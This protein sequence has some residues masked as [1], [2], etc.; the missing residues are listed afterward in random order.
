[1]IARSLAKLVRKHHPDLVISRTLTRRD[2]RTITDNPLPDTLT[3]SLDD[4]V[5][6]SDLIMECSG[7]PF[8]TT[9]VVAHAFQAGLPVVTMN[10]E[11]HVTTGSHFVG[12]GFLTEA[13]GDQPGSLGVLRENVLQMGFKPLVYGNMKGFLNQNPSREDMEYWSRHQGISLEQCIAA[14][15]GTKIQIEQVLVGNGFGATISR[16]GLEGPRRDDTVPA[17]RELAALAASIGQPIS[18]YL[19]SGKQL[20]GMFIAGTHDEE[21]K[22][23]LE[24]Y[25]GGPGPYYVVFTPHHMCSLEAVKTIRRVAQGGTELLNNSTRPHLSCAA[26]AKLPLAR[27]SRIERGIGSFETR[28]EA[29]RIADHPNHVPI[30]LL[31]DAVVR[32]SIEPGQ[33]I[34][35][36]DVELPDTDVY[37]IVRSIYG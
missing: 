22:A 29:I 1:M 17:A 10:A 15:D 11:F 27:G 18:D 30:G 12:K 34:T 23:E 28:G 9:A 16:Q 13:E 26:L 25:K 33:I 2:P 31:Q 8:H 21:Q 37:R 20:P 6:N 14:T 5:A 7:D 4:L 3:R 19:V 32:Q 24:Y 36:D 35:Y